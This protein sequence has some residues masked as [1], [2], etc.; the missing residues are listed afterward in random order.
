[1]LVIIQG[2][3]SQNACQDSKQRRPWSDCFFRSRLIWVCTVSLCLF[4][5]VPSVR[6]LRTFTVHVMTLVWQKKSNKRSNNNDA[7]LILMKPLIVS[8]YLQRRKLSSFLFG[9]KKMCLNLPPMPSFVIYLLIFWEY[10]CK[11]WHYNSTCVTCNV[12]LF[13]ILKYKG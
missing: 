3:N 4:L 1:M 5:Q 9:I 10:M 2:W 12:M 6:Y 13:A 8:R 11:A 7:S